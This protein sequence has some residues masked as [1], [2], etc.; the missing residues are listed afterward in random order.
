[1]D[2]IQVAQERAEEEGISFRGVRTDG[3]LRALPG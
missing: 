3:G 1:M 2:R